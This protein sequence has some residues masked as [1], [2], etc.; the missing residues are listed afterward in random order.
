[1]SDPGTNGQS[2]SVFG[3]NTGSSSNATGTIA[4]SSTT[5]A[6]STSGN[7]APPSGAE[8]STAGLPVRPA[9]A[10]TVQSSPPPPS[11][12]GAS[13]APTASLFGPS[14][15]GASPGG[16]TSIFGTGTST[17][18]SPPATGTSGG[19]FGSQP[20][21]TTPASTTSA[22]P[23]T[24]TSSVLFGSRP[25]S[26]TT[27]PLASAASGGLFGSRPASTATA[28]GAAGSSLFGSAPA[29][30]VF[31]APAATATSSSSTPGSSLFGSTPAAMATAPKESDATG[32]KKPEGSTSP[33]RSVVDIDI[34]GD[35]LLDIGGGEDSELTEVQRFRVCSSTLRR[36]SPVWK[37]MLFGPWKESKPAGAK[38]NEWIV[39]FPDDNVKAMEVVLNIMHGRFKQVPRCLS[40]DQL[41]KLLILTNK[42][43]LTELLR[44]WCAQWV[45]VAY[46]DLSS[47]DTLKTLFIA[48]ELG[49]DGLFALR[50]EEI[51]VNTR[52]KEGSMFTQLGTRFSIKSASSLVPG[53]IDLEVQ[54]YLGPHDILDVIHSVRKEAL[55]MIT[56]AIDKDVTRRRAAT[57]PKVCPGPQ[58]QRHSGGWGET[59]S[60]A[61]CDA[62]ILGGIMIHLD[63]RLIPSSSVYF[64]G[65]LDTIVQV[66]S[67]LFPKIKLIEYLPGHA[68]CSLKT[69]YEILDKKIHE[70]LPKIVAKHIKP[71]HKEYMKSQRSKTGIEVLEGEVRK[72]GKN[73]YW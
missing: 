62:A 35:L 27:A 13:S 29:Q 8:G 50:I 61:L 40:L 52:S 1:M 71:A 19:L 45:S 3:S 21:S 42:Y 54:D 53:W 44:P 26:T 51:S 69:Q 30:G 7:P 17:T 64:L 23:A 72:A 73:R 48:W 4:S 37:Q 34:D 33:Q 58:N 59:G 14:T 47:V 28:S 11:L 57:F 31:G 6:S 66:A 60:A 39:E 63:A 9:P 65:I 24:A 55:S 67:G 32:T 15:G 12:F 43:D 25:A 38:S 68:R 70:D 5:A 41:Y 10:P 36:H 18:A 20:S 2:T 49:H 16:S 56:S 22:A 46:G